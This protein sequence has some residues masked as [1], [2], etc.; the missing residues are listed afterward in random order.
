MLRSSKMR[1]DM[2]R[3]IGRNAKPFRVKGTKKS[4][5]EQIRKNEAEAQTTVPFPECF[6]QANGESSS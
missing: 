1:L 4:H 2:Q 3:F 6:G 5:E